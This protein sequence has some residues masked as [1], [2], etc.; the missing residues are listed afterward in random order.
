MHA[1]PMLTFPVLPSDM[2]PCCPFILASSLLSIC[3]LL[4]VVVS[5]SSMS[6]L[7]GLE[8]ERKK[9]LGY[10][11]CLRTLM[12]WCSSFRKLFCPVV[13]VLVLLNKHLTIV[14]F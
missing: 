5:F 3:A 8:K 9:A 14:P 10:P 13:L 7:G 2:H 4:P 6:H 11:F 12:R 1:L